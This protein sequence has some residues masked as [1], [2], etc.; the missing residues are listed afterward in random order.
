MRLCSI[1]ARKG[2]KGFKNK[3]VRPFF[4]KPLIAHIIMIAKQSQLFDVIAVSSDCDEIL[5]IADKFGV[6][7]LIKR[8]DE[9]ATDNAAKLPAI[10]HCAIEVEKRT[11][12]IFETFVDLSVTSPLML[13]E[14]ICGAIKLL[15]ESEASNVVTA[16]LS[17]HSP[18]F[19]M[20]EKNINGFASLVKER[21]QNFTR[22]QDC[23][24]SYDMNG[25]IYVWKRNVFF[26]LTEII[27][28]KTL[29]YEMP[30]ERSIDIDTEFDFIISNFMYS[31]RELKEYE[32]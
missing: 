13:P 16:C 32:N 12:A 30:K 3:N 4:G 31:K 2:S 11:G 14:D 7:H 22:R 6:K 29:I 28:D 8:P 27:T 20:L 26:D 18:Y 1:C 24:P 9:M 15:E 10:Q 5:N 23:P 25:A 17:S 21:A 19:S